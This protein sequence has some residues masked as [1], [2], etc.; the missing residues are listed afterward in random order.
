MTL[1][2]HINKQNIEI[3]VYDHKEILNKN[4]LYYSIVC[5]FFQN[6]KRLFLKPDKIILIPSKSYLYI[7]IYIHNVYKIIYIYIIRKW[8]K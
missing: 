3:G 1:Y 5:L 2:F 4:L 8:F 7:L 6:Y